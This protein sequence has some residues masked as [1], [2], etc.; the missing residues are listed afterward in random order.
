MGARVHFVFK[1]NENE[2]YTVLYSH[3][4]DSSW[5]EDLKDAMSIA[6]PR[7]GDWSYFTRI[8]ISQLIREDWDKETGYGLYS[9]NPDQLNNLGEHTVFIDMPNG[10][11]TDLDGNMEIFP[12]P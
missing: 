9:I 5:K 2:P 4:G 7:K 10:V 12:I 8:V 1:Q 11:V 6:S 3:W